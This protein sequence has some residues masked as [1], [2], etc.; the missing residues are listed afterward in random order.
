MTTIDDKNLVIHYCEKAKQI[1]VMLQ[2]ELRYARKY[3][4]EKK[5]DIG[6]YISLVEIDEADGLFKKIENIR[7]LRGNEIVVPNGGPFGWVSDSEKLHNK[8][9]GVI[10]SHGCFY[11]YYFYNLYYKYRNWIEKLNVNNDECQKVYSCFKNLI[12]E[13]MEYLFKFEDGMILG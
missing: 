3:F 11:G 5:D 1:C 6:T 8:I 9:K 10:V 7:L 4:E 2:N 13:R 12:K